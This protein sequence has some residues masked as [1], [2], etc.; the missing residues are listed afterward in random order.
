M[1]KNNILK[2]DLHVHSK[3]SERPSEWILQTIGTK[4]SYTKPEYIYKK[5]KEKGMDLV[6]ITDHNRIDGVLKLKEKYPDDVFTGV[7]TTTYFPEDG[8]KIHLLIYNFTQEQFKII[9][10]LRKDIYSLRTFIK[11]NDLPYSV[12]HASYSIN[13]KLNQEHLE[14]LILLFDNFEG[15]NGGR[16]YINNNSWI[17]ILKNLT[18]ADI[19]KLIN[20]YQ[21]KPYS[22]TPWIKAFTGGSDDHA[23]LFLGQTYTEIP[24]NNKK[25]FLKGLREK[26]STCFGREND[27]HSLAFTLYK[28]G[29]DFSKNKKNEFLSPIFENITELIFNE[30][31]I[32]LKDKF[33][34]SKLKKASKK[35]NNKTKQ[36]IINLVEDNIKNKNI[37]IDKK[38]DNIYNN[39]SEITDEYFRTTI[40]SIHSDIKKLDI[41]NLARKLSSSLFGVFLTI[42]FISTFK[43]MFQDRKLINKMEQKYL[44]DEKNKSENNILWFTDTINDLNGVSVT[45]KKI[46][47]LSKKQNYN[48]NIISALTEKE[49]DDSLP[50]N[51]ITLPYI[52]SFNPKVYENYKLKIPSLLKSLKIIYDLQPEKI[53]ISTP[54]PVGLIGLLTAKLMNLDCEIVYHTDFTSEFKEIIGD[55]PILDTL[56]AYM[57]WF[58]NQ[59]QKILVASIYYKKLLLRRGYSPEKIKLF[60]R[61]LDLNQYNYKSLGKQFIKINYNIKEKN[62]LLYTGRISKDKNLKFISEIFKKIEGKNYNLALLIV[63]NGPYLKEFKQEFSSNQNV[64]FTGRVSQNKLPYIYSGSDLFL[65]PSNTD[66]FGMSVLEAQSCRTPAIVSNIGGPKEIVKNNLT[67][68]IISTTNK[69]KWIKKIE[70]YL[71]LKNNEK[72]KYN[73]ICDNC[74]NMVINNYNLNNLLENILSINNIEENLSNQLTLK[75]E[76]NKTKIS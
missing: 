26:K 33:Y 74:E 32:N 29:Y 75:T 20:K 5:C 9:N 59:G 13:G 76:A 66:T 18:P 67:G 64:Y 56:N 12:A 34:I 41:I 3:Y 44:S 54:G 43:H 61:G 1:Y 30:R 71:N 46:G 62:I 14:K 70:Y 11:E 39:I 7:E 2:A 37:N 10:E 55:D 22:T 65:F 23:G 21:I 25:T 16:N 72:D 28:I 60:K 50:E 36:L 4:E 57:R 47:E 35:R 63:G 53:I 49:I 69:E 52:Y 42:P 73:N 15:K 48:L 45:L 17:K 58:Y 40:Q 6:T 51:L 19:D 38:L 68:N 8:C 27:F 31:K 24:S